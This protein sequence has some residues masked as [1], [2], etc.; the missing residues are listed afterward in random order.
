MPQGRKP[1]EVFRVCP[2]LRPDGLKRGQLPLW[3]QNPKEEGS[4]TRFGVRIRLTGASDTGDGQ[5]S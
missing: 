5:D 2:C 3:H 4:P 1:K